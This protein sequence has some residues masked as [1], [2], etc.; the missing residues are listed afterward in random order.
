[1]RCSQSA[2]VLVF[3][4]LL[5]LAGATGF[6]Q[7][8]NQGAD[9]YSQGCAVCH[10][11]DGKGSDRGTPIA[12]QPSVIAMSDADLLGVLHNGASGGMPA[13]PQL[14]EQQA[15]AVVLYL[16]QLQGVTGGSAAAAI[17]TGD[18]NAGKNLFFGKGQCSNCHMV[19]GKGGFMAPDMTSYSKNHD[20]AAILQA[21]V[22]PDKHLEPTSRVVEVVTKAGEKISGVVR[23]EDDLELTLQTVD[24]RYHFLNRGSLAKVTYTGHSLMPHDYATRLTTQELNDL[25]DYL[26]VTGKNTPAVAASARGWHDPYDD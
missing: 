7:R 19:S 2:K 11:A 21:I 5:L 16:R 3:C 9:L 6:G 1:M 24:G 15:K 8:G 4:V 12:S 10:G 25:V 18:V 22:K 23:A 17:P 26:I 14:T 13:F 20:A